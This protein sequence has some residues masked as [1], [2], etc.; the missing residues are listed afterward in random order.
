MSCDSP[1][2]YS[3]ELVYASQAYTVSFGGSTTIPALSTPSTSLCLPEIVCLQWTCGLG[4]VCHTWQWCKCCSQLCM[5]MG[6]K[7][8]CSTIPGTVLWPALNLSASMDI[9][10]VFQLA[11]GYEINVD[12]P[13]G[14]I[15]T[16]SIT[17]Q[18][19]TFRLSVNGEGFSIS[20]PINL[21]V[22]QENGSFSATIPLTSIKESYSSAG[23]EYSIQF[24]FNLLCCATPESPLSW[25][26]I[27]VN[28]VI[29]ALGI[30]TS[31]SMACPITAA[32]EEPDA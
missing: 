27:Q 19:F 11:D 30:N 28:G 18:S 12:T 3:E 21:T 32:E 7:W 17:I 16:S 14:P 24:G 25:M 2:T 15:E 26:N 29:S 5:D 8:V 9:P 1:F 13:S 23:I 22:E 20:V 4:C 10:M 6:T 31:F